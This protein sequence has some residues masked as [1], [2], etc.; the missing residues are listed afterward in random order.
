VTI[1]LFGNEI[2]EEA[3][4]HARVLAGITTKAGLLNALDEALRFPDYFG[5]N[6]DALAECINDLS[7]L[8][9]GDVALVHEDVPLKDDRR[10]LATYLSI[11]R[12]AVEEWAAKKERKLLVLFPPGTE[13]LV[14]GAAPGP[15][16][17]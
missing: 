8:P 15:F 13:E 5:D 16:A 10:S 2:P 4:F 7:W 9:D 11:L 3:A 1:F 17:N 12:G 14:Q 6:W